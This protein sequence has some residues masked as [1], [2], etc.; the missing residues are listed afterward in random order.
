[1]RPGD[2]LIPNAKSDGAALNGSADGAR[3]ITAAVR[4]PGEGRGV[5][6]RPAERGGARRGSEKVDVGNLEVQGRIG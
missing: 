5:Q 2:S 1:M 6:F 3:W 4:A